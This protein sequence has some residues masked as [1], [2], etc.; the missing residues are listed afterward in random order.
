MSS[1]SN[2]SVSN[3]D[4]VIERVETTILRIPTIRAHALSVATMSDQRLVIVK[5][6]SSDGMVG[7]G[8]AATIGGLA[9]TDESPESIKLTIDTYMAPTLVGASPAS[10]A[11]AMMA[12]HTHIVGNYFAKNAV[13]TALLDL[14]GKLLGVP[15]SELLGG[16]LTSNLSVAWT[17][18]SGD[19]GKDI[20]EG[21]SMLAARRHNIFKLKIGRRDWQEDVA[22]VAAIAAEFSGE[23]SIRVD[24]N[25]AWDL[26]T[27]KRAIPALADAGVD[28]VEQP[29]RGDDHDGAYELRQLSGAAIMADEALRGGITPAFNIAKARAADVV[30]LKIAQAGGLFAC[31]D[32]ARLALSAGMEL[33]GGTMLEGGIATAASAQVF[34]TLPTILW[35][36]ELFGPLLLTAE[37]LK[38][39]LIYRDFSLL[40]PEG[41]GLGVELDEDALTEFEETSL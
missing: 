37:I 6:T 22:H 41:P 2:I 29:L 25:Q 18:A 28:L 31:R 11:K 9:Y 20:E 3:G 14:Q 36:T 23:A 34:A 13:E 26:M 4:A 21:R 40:V 12:I 15:V 24:V 17:L 27:A 39:P 30:S 32:V 5:I 16:R 38:T 33:Y 1:S 10:P 35:G 19:T 7:Y 8:E